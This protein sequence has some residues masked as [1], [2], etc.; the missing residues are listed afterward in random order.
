M[1]R[2]GKSS[3]ATQ[4]LRYGLEALIPAVKCFGTCRSSTGAGEYF[5]HGGKKILDG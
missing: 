5:T 4:S 1:R 3:K 2:Y